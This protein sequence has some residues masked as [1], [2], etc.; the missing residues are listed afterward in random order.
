MKYDAGSMKPFVAAQYLQQDAAGDKLAGEVDSNYWGLKAGASIDALTAYIAYS[1]QSDSDATT[2]AGRLLN[3]TITPW[4]GMP[5]F[6]QGMVTR[7]QFIAGTDAFKLAASY[8]FKD[9]GLKAVAYYAEYDMDNNSGYGTA[10]TT[11]E[12]GFD[13]I[14]KPA[15]VKNL[16]LRLRG[17]FPTDYANNVDWNEYRFIATYKF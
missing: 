4:G 17:N 10:R 16:Q 2:D 6:T 12:P 11:K 13:F 3:S 1:Q 5:A 15:A 9:M 8:N 14:Y 7:H